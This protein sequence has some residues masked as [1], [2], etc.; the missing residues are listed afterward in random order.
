M[1][2]YGVDEHETCCLTGFL[3]KVIHEA[4]DS[5]TEDTEEKS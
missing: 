2:L 3:L 5:S 4:A 1:L